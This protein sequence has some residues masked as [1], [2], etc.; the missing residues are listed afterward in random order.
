MPSLPE[1]RH[2]IN[3]ERLARCKKGVR[4]VNTARGELIDEAALADAIESGHVAGAGARRVRDRAAGRQAP[5]VAA[6]GRRDAA[7]RGVDERSAGARRHRDRGQRARLP[8]GRG[9]P[10]RGEFP[11]VPPDECR[12]CGRICSSPR[13]SARWS[14][15]WPTARPQSIGIRYYGPLM[16][17]TKTIIGSAVLAGAV[18]TDGRRRDAGQRARARRASAASRSSSRAAAAAGFRE[19]HFGEAAASERRALGRG[20]GLRAGEPAPLALD[21]VPTSKRRSPA[22][23]SCMANDDRPGVIG[24]VGTALGRHGVNI[25]SF[26]LGRD[27]RGAVGVIGV[28]EADGRRRP[29][30]EVR[31]SRRFAKRGRARGSRVGL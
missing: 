5:D 21:G 15:S 20:N 6:A 8:A 12:S 18:A 31:D 4:I 9:H 14:R 2:V 16:Q 1:T 28:D 27:E 11:A 19:H 23:S 17:R 24:D 3:A 29:S 22:R 25:A 10:E 26:A 7:H 30:A 13:S